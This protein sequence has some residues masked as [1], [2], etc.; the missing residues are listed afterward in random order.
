MLR[1]QLCDIQNKH[2]Q[3]ILMRVQYYN[4]NT[5]NIPADALSRLCGIVS[6]TNHTPCDNIRLLPMSK[7]AEIYRKH[8][9]T[10]DPLVIQ[11][12]IQAGIDLECV[13]MVNLIENRTEYRDIPEQCELMLIHDSMPRLGIC[14]LRDG[15]RLIV[16]NGENS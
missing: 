16:R 7:K 2:L 12:G 8:L 1:K 3:K 9:E 13:Q 4:F 10:E 11:L 14:E 5:N 15:N 6:K